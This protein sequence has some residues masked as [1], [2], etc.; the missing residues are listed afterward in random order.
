MKAKRT[1]L[2]V[3]LLALAHSPSF[4]ETQ[5]DPKTKKDAQIANVSLYILYPDGGW[6]FAVIY[7]SRNWS[8]SYYVPPERGKEKSKVCEGVIIPSVDSE[9][10]LAASVFQTCSNDQLEAEISKG[11]NSDLKELASHFKGKALIVIN[12]IDGE[13]RV[14]ERPYNRKFKNAKTQELDDV[15][16]SQI[17][18][19]KK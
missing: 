11:L 3:F 19:C 1:L 17:K 13:R 15:L 2:T 18:T 12:T 7:L 6:D 9:F 8:A 16:I 4:G 5:R 10:E 14:F